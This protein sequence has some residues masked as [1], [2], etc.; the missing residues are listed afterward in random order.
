[1]CI[2]ISKS[3]C[4]VLLTNS[5]NGSLNVLVVTRWSGLCHGGDNG[6]GRGGVVT[7]QSRHG[8][9]VVEIEPGYGIGDMIQ[10]VGYR[11]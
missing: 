1:M 9:G 4:T 6:I 7:R 2:Y 5:S 8:R 11:H 10:G 3:S